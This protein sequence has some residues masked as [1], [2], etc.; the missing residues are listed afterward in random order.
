MS[1]FSLKISVITVV[2]N[3]S[4]T[5]KDSI[6]SVLSQNYSDI[7]Y[8]IVDGASNDGTIDVI[9]GY[10]DRFSVVLSEPD[11]G[12][13]DAMNKG[14]SLATGDV[15][16]F[17]HAD[18]IYAH[19]EVLHT[20][21]G[22]FKK[23]DLDACFSDLVYVDRNNTDKV[24]RY[25]KSN[26]YKKGSFEKGWCPPHPTLFIKKK[27][28]EKYGKF[29]LKYKIGNDVELMMRLIEKYQIK[30]QYVPGVMIKM[31]VGGESNK[32]I[33]NIVKQNIE[34]LKAALNNNLSINPLSFFFHK[35]CSR[36]FQFL[37]KP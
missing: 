16:G 19:N 22:V 5:I 3:N 9:N 8:I 28:Y 31:R 13:Y 23:Q 4:D 1:S 26:D 21:S 24:V 37:N 36:T 35:A 17:L 27:V 18:D 12:K 15:I 7:E 33:A 10:E 14:I 30:T 6:E 20:V 32:S 34:I 25:W 2:Y 11:N 29:D